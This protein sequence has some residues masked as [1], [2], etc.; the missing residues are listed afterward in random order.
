MQSH[1]HLTQENQQWCFTL[2]GQPVWTSL[3]KATDQLVQ[4]LNKCM[5]NQQSFEFIGPFG[6]YI[7]SPDNRSFYHRENI[8]SRPTHAL[9]EQQFV[10]ELKRNTTA[11]FEIASDDL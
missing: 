4:I 6:G 3:D 8:L 9:T 1:I 10:D 2:Q 11:A 5:D 7:F